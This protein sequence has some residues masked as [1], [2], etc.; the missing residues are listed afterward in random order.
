MIQIFKKHIKEEMIIPSKLDKEEPQMNFLEDV[1][2]YLQLLFENILIYFSVI[3]WANERRSSNIDVDIVNRI[4]QL[5]DCV[6]IV[7]S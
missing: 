7:T 5:L 3:F 6:Y 4:V 1:S 2:F